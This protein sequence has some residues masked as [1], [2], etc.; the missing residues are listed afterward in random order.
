MTIRKPSYNYTEREFF[1]W[2][3]DAAS[4]INRN[5][6]QSSATVRV[7]RN[8]AG[9]ILQTKLTQTTRR[10]SAIVAEAVPFQV[11]LGV[12]QYNNEALTV[13]FGSIEM[14]EVSGVFPY[15]VNGVQAPTAILES[16][17]IE[18][19]DLYMIIKWLPE[20]VTVDGYT[21]NYEVTFTIAASANDIPL[22]AYDQ[23]VFKLAVITSETVDTVTV[24]S[25]ESIFNKNVESR[26][27]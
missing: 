8:E 25:V 27:L 19:G 9:T 1:N 15:P 24:F 23:S 20:D 12:D 11:G 26:W 16:L 14:G 5:Q 4:E 22:A 10:T 18:D 13:N 3:C 6:C 7:Q 17:L 2:C 21:R